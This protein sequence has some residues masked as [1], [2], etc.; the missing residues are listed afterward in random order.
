MLKTTENETEGLLESWRIG[1]NAGKGFAIGAD[2]MSPEEA[3]EDYG[4]T[5]IEVIT[6]DGSVVGCDD[7]GHAIVVR[8]HNGPWAVDVTVVELGEGG[9]AGNCG[10][11]N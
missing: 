4:L 7:D 8:D 5:E 11:G 9:G 3:A 10:F 6:P 2:D 1:N